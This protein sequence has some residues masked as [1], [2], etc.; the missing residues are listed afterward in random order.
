MRTRLLMVGLLVAATAA[1]ATALQIRGGPLSRVEATETIDDDLYIASSR[2]SID[3]RINGDVIAAGGSVR[4]RG[5]VDGDALIAGGT[6]EVTGRVGETVRAAAGS[7]TIEGRVGAD[8][9]VVGA[10]VDIDRNAQVTRDVAATGGSVAVRG[11][12]GRHVI[13]AGGRVVI[14]GNVG[15]NVLVRGGE[16]IVEDTA[17]VRGNLTYSSEQPVRVS[18]NARI[19]GRVIQEAYPVRPMP[20]AR[21]TRAF[22]VVFGFV[23]FLW[24]LVLALAMVAL[25]PRGVAATADA[26][27][28]RPWASLGWGILLLI[29]IPIAVI[30]LAVV[31]VGIPVAIVLLL[32]HLLAVFASHAAA[33]LAIGRLV[34]T[35]ASAYGQ[36]AAGVLIIAIATNLPVAGVFLRVAIIALGLGAVAIAFWGRRRA[37]GMR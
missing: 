24:M 7:L 8:V 16:V 2:V 9:V 35:R 21:A 3:G 10:D 33:A 5:Q 32:A 29:G 14:A 17:V 28:A 18:P 25:V 31:L 22:R 36:V 23:D 34:I 4:V 20:S 12:V 1:P 6:V 13:V 37:P 30:V 26:L 15:G 27:G 11:T 19:S